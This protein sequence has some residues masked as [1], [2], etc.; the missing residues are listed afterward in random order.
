MPSTREHYT[1]QTHTVAADVFGPSAPGRHPACLVLHGTF[2]LLPAYQA[3]LL[4]FGRAL[5]D[6][7]IVAVLPHYFDRTGTPP[8]PAAAHA[9]AQ[10]L[11]D[12]VSACADGLLF[13]GHDPRV[14]AGRLGAIGFSLGGHIAMT[15]AMAP[16][17]GTTLKCVVDFFGPTLAPTLCGSR[18]LM[19]PVQIHH[20]ADDDIVPIAES[21]HLVSELRAVGKVEGLGYEFFTYARQGHGFKGADLVSSR[22]KTVAFVKASL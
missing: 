17:P 22:A 5:A 7:G 16:P 2:G 12:W 19:P 9:I 6:A 18:S 13:A 8:G 14:D 3:D 4:S 21:E 1:S 15:L 11:P 20:G 10:C